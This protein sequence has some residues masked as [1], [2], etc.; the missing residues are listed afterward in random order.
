MYRLHCMVGLHQY[1]WTG[2]FWSQWSWAAKPLGA[3]EALELALTENA[4]F[5]LI[6]PKRG[7]RR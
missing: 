3:A 6:P 4:D 1:Y 7:K 5:E 2:A